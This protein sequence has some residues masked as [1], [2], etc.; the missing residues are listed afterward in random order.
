MG[1]LFLLKTEKSLSL[2]FI[3][4]LLKKKY[5]ILNLFLFSLLLNLS[6]E[7]KQKKTQIS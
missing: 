3:Q 5:E 4:T 6:N 1:V 7:P 2:I